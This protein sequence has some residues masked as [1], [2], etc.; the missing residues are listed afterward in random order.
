VARAA[1][2]YGVVKKKEGGEVVANAA[3]TLRHS[4]GTSLT[5]VLQTDSTGHFNIKGL[6]A[7]SVRLFAK[8]DNMRSDLDGPKR[9]E[10]KGG[11]NAGPIELLL[12]PG[13]VMT[14]KVTSSDD[15]KPVVRATL[16]IT[17]GTLIWIPIV[18]PNEVIKR[19]EFRTD[20]GAE[21]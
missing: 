9:I 10:I 11:D 17:T 5:Q 19:G 1:T 6:A 18:Q 8:L 15:G 20:S 2:V 7:G 14:G 4:K 16:S 13:E 21:R 3:V 12:E